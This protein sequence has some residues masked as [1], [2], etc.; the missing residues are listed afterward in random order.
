MEK[1]CDMGEKN[2]KKIELN[3]AGPIVLELWNYM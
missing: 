3:L 1:Q 2:L